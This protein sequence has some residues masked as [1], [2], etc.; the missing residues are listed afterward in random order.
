MGEG[1]DLSDGVKSLVSTIEKTAGLPRS[2]YSLAM[3]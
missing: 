1:S 3:R 2:R